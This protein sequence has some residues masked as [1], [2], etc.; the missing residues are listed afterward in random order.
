MQAIRDAGFPPGVI[1]MV[2]GSGRDIMTPVLRP[3]R[4]HCGQLHGRRRHRAHIAGSLFCAMAQRPHFPRFVAETGG[5]DF[6]V[7]DRDCDAWDAACVHRP[8][9]LRAQRAEVLGEQPG[10]RRTS[11]GL[12]GPRGRPPRADEVVARGRPD[13]MRSP[14]WGRSSTGAPTRA[15]TGYI[16]RAKRDPKVKT[17]WGGE[18]TAEKG[19]W[20]QPT[21]FE[22]DADEHEL[23]RE[24]IFG[25]VTAIRVVEDAE[26]A[27]R[28]IRKHPYRLTGAVWSRDE[29][30]LDRWVPVFSE[31]A[32]N[33]YINRKTTGAM[34]D[35]QPFGGD[36]LSGTNY[37]AGGAWYLL[38]VPE[39]GDRSRGGTRATWWI[40]DCG[41]GVGNR[42]EVPMGTSVHPVCFR[43]TTRFL[44][45]LVLPVTLLV[46][47]ATPA[48]AQDVQVSFDTG[49]RVLTMTRA[50]AERLDLLLDEYPALTEARLFREGADIWIL[51]VV[52]RRDGELVRE[53]KPLSVEEAA[54]LRRQVSD[55]LAAH[56]A[57][58]T[59]VGPRALLV[60]TY[61][62]LGLFFY[63]WAVPVVLDVEEA[64]AA[65]G[66]G[67]LAAGAS[68]YIP[69]K[70]TSGRPV[71]YGEAEMVRTGAIRGLVDGGLLWALLGPDD[72]ESSDDDE[73]PEDGGTAMVMG[74]SI[75]GGAIG[76]RWARAAQMTPGTAAMIANG[77]DFGMLATGGLLVLFEV[78]E[79]RGV[80][81]ALLAGGAGGVAMAYYRARPRPYS[82]G[83]AQ[84]VRDAGILGA[85]TGMMVVDWTGS[86]D[87]KAI[88]SVALVGMAA[89]LAVGDR[90]V[91]RTELTPGQA[92]LIELGM[93]A[94]SV[95]GLGVAYVLASDD[96]DESVYLTSAVAGAA[97]GYGLT[98]RSMR[99]NSR[100]VS[101][102]SLE[103][104]LNPLGLLALRSRNEG[105]GRDR[106]RQEPSRMPLLAV[107]CRF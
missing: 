44:G 61:C 3:P 48:P 9:R 90:L 28:I 100:P 17:L 14:T 93:I 2:T 19:F 105:A 33:F 98:F 16:E 23:L 15:I 32:G 95:A 46:L 45:L 30:W 8:R 24:E 64:G 40:R 6:M 71:T 103:L 75:V 88:A 7:V 85:F 62:L 20:V 1:N 29:A 92:V 56:G 106:A 11:T 22:V 81:G 107:S 67:L 42:E 21:L 77:S 91:Q 34:V 76:S 63:D 36:G 52:S 104:K 87:E 38:A 89:G 55:R 31:Y 73:S 18:H 26:Q 83:D 47:A 70:L 39:P 49:G 94:G 97:A 82:W 68:Y 69:Y 54:E 25:P 59:S 51:E 53:R 5:K 96:A 37:K 58:D 60:G 66:L 84:A 41:V 43:K 99:R 102:S 13:A 27:L 10:A 65:V 12:A 72:D 50:T 57:P 4:A 79:S 80:A 86:E 101:Q 35:Q 74:A 78:E